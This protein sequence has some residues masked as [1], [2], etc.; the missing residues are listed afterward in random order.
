M[1][2][3]VRKE[4]NGWH[5][6]TDRLNYG[7]FRTKRRAMDMR[8]AVIESALQ[9]NPGGRMA[10]R[11]LTSFD[12]KWLAIAKSVLAMHPQRHVSGMGKVEAEGIIRELM[13]RRGARETIRRLLKNP[14]ENPGDVDEAGWHR[15]THAAGFSVE[16]KPVSR[17]RAKELYGRIPRLGHELVLPSEG[18]YQYRLVNTSGKLELRRWQRVNPR[19][20]TAH[21]R[22]VRLRPPGRFARE[23]LRTIDPGKPGGPKV[24]VG[25]LKG[26]RR[27]TRSGRAA[28]TP[29][30]KLYPRGKNP[31]EVD[32]TAATEL[33]LFIENDGDLYRRQTIP[34]LQNLWRKMQRG[35]YD[36]GKAAKLWGYLVESGAKKYVQE[37]GGPGDKWHQV[38][39]VPTRAAVARSLADSGKA[40]LD[41]REFTWQQKGNPGVHT[42]LRKNPTLVTLGANPLARVVEDIGRVEEIRYQRTAKGPGHQQL[43]KHPFEQR[44]RLL[45]LS[46]GTVHIV[47][48]THRLWANLPE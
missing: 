40:Q 28:L 29:Q 38:F 35:V 26:E 39:D 23:S 34:I 15:A 17:K 41:G 24:V 45:L 22:R 3:W 20:T 30:A 11:E 1:N 12:R 21:Y 25:R 43:F 16:W 5:V 44:P 27:V 47:H 19:E 9:E 13:G 18:G 2:V 37:F 14:R 10:N 36:H 4:R 46:D 6:V 32:E 31:R 42:R 48:P 33:T 8:E 7:P